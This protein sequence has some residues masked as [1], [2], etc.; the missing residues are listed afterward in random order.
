MHK[1]A[2]SIYI[3]TCVCKFTLDIATHTND[4]IARHITRILLENLVHRFQPF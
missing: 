4:K 2:R 1:G 3:M